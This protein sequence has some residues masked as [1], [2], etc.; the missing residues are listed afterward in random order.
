MYTWWSF[1][2][3]YE[4]VKYFVSVRNYFLMM[5]SGAEE[6]KLPE[7]AKAEEDTN[8]AWVYSFGAAMVPFCSFCYGHQRGMTGRVIEKVVKSRVGVYGLLAL[9]FLTL[10]MEKSIYD[11]VQCWQGV[12]PNIRP[13]GRG[14]FPSGGAELPSFSLIP[15]QKK[16]VTRLTQPLN[17]EQ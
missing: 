17:A 2:A 7:A 5:S 11:T 14:G 15:L 3:F 4:L 10:G 12:D 13:K 8:H 6:T 16:T 9:P 1:A